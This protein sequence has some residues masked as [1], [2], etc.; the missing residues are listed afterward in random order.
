MRSRRG[1]FC[2]CR[3]SKNKRQGDERGRTNGNHAHKERVPRRND[4]TTRRRQHAARGD[5]RP[6]VG[7]RPVGSTTQWRART[8]TLQHPNHGMLR[9]KKASVTPRGTCGSRPNVNPP[10]STPYR[11]ANMSLGHSWE[12]VRTPRAPSPA[13]MA[14]SRTAPNQRNV[15]TPPNEPSV[16]THTQDDTKLRPL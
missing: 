1:I 10:S 12:H 14:L 11:R 16:V 13:Q 2:E 6:S 3:Q 4:T 9:Q 15:D 8:A 7:S 5:R